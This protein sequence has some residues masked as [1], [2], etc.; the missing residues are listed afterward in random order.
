MYDGKYLYN[1]FILIKEI[2]AKVRNKK[3][4]ILTFC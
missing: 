3:I 1:K 4:E 2:I